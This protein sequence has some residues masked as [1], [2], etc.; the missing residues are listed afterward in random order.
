M[1]FHTAY[2]AKRKPEHPGQDAPLRMGPG[3]VEPKRLS[4]QG[5]NKTPTAAVTFHREKPRG[6]QACYHDHDLADSFHLVI[7]ATGEPQPAG[8]R[9]FL[10]CGELSRATDEPA[11]FRAATR[12]SV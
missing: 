8:G 5:D 4:E 1:I 9:P 6:A 11:D 3:G 2:S 12:S 10:L 7:R